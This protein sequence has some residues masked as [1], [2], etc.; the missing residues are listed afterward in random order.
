MLPANPPSPEEFERAMAHVPRLK[1]QARRRRRQRR[2]LLGAAAGVAAATAAAL[3][4]WLVPASH[5]STVRVISPASTTPRPA[6]PTTAP[7]SPSPLAGDIGIL[8]TFA[9]ESTM[10]WWA[11]VESNLTSQAYVA[12]T[13]DGGQSWQDVL[14]PPREGVTASDFLDTETAWVATGGPGTSNPPLYRTTDGGRTWQRFGTDPGA[15]SLQF[16]D[17][18]HGWCVDIGA[19][20]GSES[21]E[22]YRTSNSGH[23]W[24]LV[25]RTSPGPGAPST[26]GALPFGCDKTINFTSAQTGY[27]AFYCNGGTPYLYKSTDGGTDWH[28]LGPVPPPAGAPRD[29]GQGFDPPAVSGDDLATVFHLGPDTAVASST[30]GGN[31]WASQLVPQPLDHWNVDLID[32]THWRLANG[33]EIMATDDAGDHWRTWTPEVPMKSSGTYGEVD[34]L[35]FLNPLQGWAVPGPDGGPA[36]ETHNGGTTWTPVHISAGP[37]ELPR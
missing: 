35:D 32:P 10:T 28:T 3:S 21:V 2:G 30:D 27:A 7:A 23:S 17:Q 36:W 18:I 9:P 26:P 13:T 6:T 15:C 16:V 20:A 8:Q 34:K 1:V 11:V 12:R 24:T 31:T 29:A 19:A 5:S 33:T 37:Y 22:L 14:V 25:S 4:A